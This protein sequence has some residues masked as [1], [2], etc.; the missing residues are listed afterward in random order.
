MNRRNFF[1]RL[2]ASGLAAGALGWAVGSGPSL[3][4]GLDFVQGTTRRRP[5]TQAARKPHNPNLDRV[6]ISS[7]SFRAYF[8]ATR[9]PD[10]KL[11][12]QMLALLDFP[13]MIA[14][15]YD[16]H[17]LEFVAPHFAS[18]EPAYLQEIKA[19]LLVAHSR[20]VNIPVDI[21]EIWNEGGLSDPKEEVRDPAIEA[22][23]KWIDIAKTLGARSVRCDPGKVNPDDLALTIDSY[24]KLVA[25]GKPKGIYVII[26]NH[27]EIA[28]HAEQLVKIFKGVGSEFIGALPDFGNF[29][30]ETARE[31]G[32]TTLFP[33]AKTV[34]HAKGLEFDASGNES[35]FDFPKCVGISKKAG[36]KGV[37]SIEYEGPGDP[38]A[39]VHAV[40]AELVRLL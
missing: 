32:L 16:V 31:R 37:Y 38:Y 13:E 15:Q 28:D 30:D 19:K 40:V 36:Y 10:S 11:T 17:N 4:P 6:G 3:G 9:E 12:G 18:A 26:E 35:K 29:S 20:L 1:S 24:K 21:K 23:K 39:G 27:G 22:S 33:Y 25:Y 2:A 5:R 14:D 8:Q 7:W 34:C